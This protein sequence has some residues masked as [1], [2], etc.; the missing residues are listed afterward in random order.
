MY[1]LISI[2]ILGLQSQCFLGSL[3]A[4][5]GWIGWHSLLLSTDSWIFD[6][7]DDL[8]TSISW[9]LGPK[10]R[11]MQFKLWVLSTSHCPSLSILVLLQA[12]DTSHVPGTAATIVHRYPHIPP[13]PI[14]IYLKET[15][16]R[17]QTRFLQLS[18]PPTPAELQGVVVSA[19]VPH[20][21]AHR[22]LSKHGYKSLPAYVFL[23]T[24]ALFSS[25]HSETKKLSLQNYLWVK[26]AL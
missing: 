23:Q 17:Y 10:V 6:Y 16:K 12:G 21:E 1:A 3:S 20:W 11:A 2:L 22:T 18:T 9:P 15:I 26:E 4:W 14:R 8:G 19:L 24:A 13:F 5:I 25:L 7:W